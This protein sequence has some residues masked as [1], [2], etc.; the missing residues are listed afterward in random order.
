MTTKQFPEAI[1]LHFSDGSIINYELDNKGFTNNGFV[2][3]STLPTNF[4]DPKARDR[5]YSTAI[6]C[7]C[8]EDAVGFEVKKDGPNKG[9]TFYKCATNKCKYYQYK[10]ELE[11]KLV[12]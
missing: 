9:R 1:S 8:N 4:N 7:A 3:A 11:K 12:Q 5:D 10:D 2:K 6:K